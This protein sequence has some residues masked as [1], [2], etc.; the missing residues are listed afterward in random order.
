M[1]SCYRRRGEEDRQ[2]RHHRSACWEASG[3]EGVLV[4]LRR[5]EGADRYVAEDLRSSDEGRRNYLRGGTKTVTSS[6]VYCGQYSQVNNEDKG[7]RILSNQTAVRCH[8]YHRHFAQVS[9]FRSLTKTKMAT[10][11]FTNMTLK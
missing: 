3:L 9:D 7:R 8:W 1:T 5:E 4:G 6:G 10:T 11:L 2:R